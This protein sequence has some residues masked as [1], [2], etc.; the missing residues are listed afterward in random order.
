MISRKH[1]FRYGTLLAVI[2]IGIYSCRVIPETNDPPYYKKKATWQETMRCSRQAMLDYFGKPGQKRS[3]PVQISPWYLAGPFPAENL[4]EVFIPEKNL[5]LL[6]RDA[7]GRLLWHQRPDFIDNKLHELPGETSTTTYLWRKI[8]VPAAI[9]I[10]GSF[11][12]KDGTDIWLNGEKIV[13]SDIPRGLEPDKDRAQL[14]LKAGANHLLMKIFAQVGK[15]GFYFKILPEPL[16]LATFLWP[17]IE[18]DFPDS[19]SRKQMDWEKNDGIWNTLTFTDEIT[20]LADNYLESFKRPAFALLAAQI[21]KALPSIET[22]SDLRQL[23]YRD[24]LVHETWESCKDF[25]FESLRMAIHDLQQSYPSEYPSGE[26][27]ISELS[28]L[29][30]EFK[31]IHAAMIAQQ[32]ANL[33]ENS[34]IQFVR[35]LLSFQRKALISNPLVSNQPILFIVRQQ[36]WGNHGPTNT[37]FQ[38]GEDFPGG[39]GGLKAWRSDGSALNMIAFDREGKTKL[40]KTLIKIPFGMIRDPDISFDGKRVLFSMRNDKADDY[41]I[42]EMNIDGSDLKQ[43]TWGTELADVDPIYLPD[44]HIAFSS[45][46]DLKYCHCNIHIQPNLFKMEEDGANIVQIG[47]GHLWEGHPSLM[48][49]GRILYS[50]WEYV[51]RQFGPSYGLWTMYP[52]GTNQSLYYG[53]NAWTPSAILDGRVIPGT[54]LVTCI[55]SGIHNL[56]WGAMTIVDRRRGLDG[57]D[58]VLKIWPAESRKLLQNIDNVAWTPY[59]IDLFH[60]PVPKYED[61]YPLADPVSGRCAGKYFLVSRS[62]GKVTHHFESTS[63]TNASYALMGIFLIDVFGNELLLHVEEPGCYDPMPVGERYKPVAIPS[64][65]NYAKDKGYFYLEN[66]YQGT[67][68]EL[69]PKGTIKYLRIVEAPPKRQ[70]SENGRGIDAAQPPAMNWNVTISKAIIGDVPVEEDGSAYFEIPAN[71]FVFFQ[72]LDKDK[73]MVQS[74][75]SGTMVQPGEM[76][77]CIGCHDNRLHASPNRR[78]S[79]MQRPASVPQAWYGPARD[80]NYLTEVQPVFDRHCTGCHDYNKPAGL[81]LNLAGDPGLVFNTSYIDIH[82]KSALRWFPDSTGAKLLIKVIHDGPPAVLPPFAWGSHR[83]RMVDVLK[84]GHKDVHLSKED[85]ERIITWIDLNAPYYGRYDAVYS[86]NP[87]ARSPLTKAQLKQLTEILD[88]SNTTN[89][90]KVN[91]SDLEKKEGS[92]FSFVRPE[93]SRILTRINDKSSWS[94]QQALLIITAGKEQLLNQPREDIPGC[95]AEPIYKKDVIRNE[96]YLRLIAAEKAA[97]QAI[98]AGKKCYP[99]RPDKQTTDQSLKKDQE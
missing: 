42:Y 38:N 77:G 52:D 34:F 59:K 86:E 27:Y 85:M 51:D 67:G 60:Y 23:Y 53:N 80:F 88:S 26:Q 91:Y 37:M 44:G 82:R 78:F 61:P 10:M 97:R 1:V 30:Q 24:H 56:P 18:R 47:G 89:L 7:E 87:F 28:R 54:S 45:T 90:P 5:D 83:S 49:D 95:P 40:L 65:V 99:F 48:P 21:A 3:D 92:Q 9:T 39:V 2:L 32:E 68:M 43:L 15:P 13:H 29:E 11:S 14:H 96:R 84:K 98:L 69:V 73:M 17:L 19:L 50:R 58:P 31:P 22:L 46:R 33:N 79:A 72:A 20:G 12:G 75:R 63:K 74:M 57:S 55:F 36:Y 66:I 8:T 25:N 94:Y 6:T 62:V 35:N 41:H 4:A 76:A 16:S 81:V 93:M 71:K 70:W 64:R